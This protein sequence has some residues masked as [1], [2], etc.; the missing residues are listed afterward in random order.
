[1]YHYTTYDS[2][3]L[4]VGER[5]DTLWNKG[6]V[7]KYQH[8]SLNLNTLS[9]LKLLIFYNG[10]P[11]S[12]HTAPPPR[13]PIDSIPRHLGLSSAPANVKFPTESH[14]NQHMYKVNIAY[15]KKRNPRL[16]TLFHQLRDCSI[17][18]FVTTGSYQPTNVYLNPL[19]A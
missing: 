7:H 10:R 13:Y 5:Q 6:P 11:T 12:P 9:F 8:I 2:S 15:K 16:K 18:V 19:C 1:M 4:S 3:L 17:A 14:T